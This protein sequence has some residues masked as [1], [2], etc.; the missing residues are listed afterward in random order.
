MSTRDL[1]AVRGSVLDRMERHERNVK[2]AAFGAALAEAGLIAIALAWI[3]WRDQFQRVVFLMFV[4][5]YS[6]VILGL[7]ALGAHVS[8]VADRMLAALTPH[9]AG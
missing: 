5:S 3:D 8:R 4:L 6:I 7:V 2:L 1:D 9:D